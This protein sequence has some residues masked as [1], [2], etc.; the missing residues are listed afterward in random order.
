LRRLFSTFA[1]GWPGAGLL[2]MRVAAGAGILARGLPRLMLGPPLQPLVL[3]GLAVT[4]SVLVVAGLW[5]PVA[6]SAVAVFG[7]WGAIS[8]PGDPWVYLLLAGIGAGLA[9]TGPGAWSIDAKLFGWKRIDV[10]E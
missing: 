10:H 4:A 8:Q 9:M 5:T 3:W 7:F 2:L 1:R 6:G